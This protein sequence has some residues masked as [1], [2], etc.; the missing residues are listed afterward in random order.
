MT[1][2]TTTTTGNEIQ[3]TATELEMIKLQREKAELEA[4]EKELKHIADLDKTVAERERDMQKKVEKLVE[5]RA[6]AKAF[7]D[8]LVS[9]KADMFTLVSKEVNIG[10]QVNDYRN[11]GREIYWEKDIKDVEYEIQVVNEKYKIR[12][13]EHLTYSSKWSRSATNKG[14]HMFL[15]GADYKEENRAIKSVKTMFNK[16]EEHIEKNNSV[17]RSKDRAELAKEMALAA[18]KSEFPDY[19][20]KHES[21]WVRSVYVKEGGTYENRIGFTLENGKHIRFSYRLLVVN[22]QDVLKL[23]LDGWAGFDYVEVINTISGLKQVK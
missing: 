12:V 16:I 5:Q 22:E 23:D 11:N 6:N 21:N 19:D 7:F 14:F 17:K 3:L 4:K 9:L 8:C 2:T 1:T 20:V 18:V 13:Y 10:G 15:I